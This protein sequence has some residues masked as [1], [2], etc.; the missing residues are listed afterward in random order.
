MKPARSPGSN[1]GGRNTNGASMEPKKQIGIQ[2]TFER[3]EDRLT[4]NFSI[5]EGTP[6]KTF[7]TNQ[8]IQRAIQQS[9]LI[10]GRI[11]GFMKLRFFGKKNVGHWMAYYPFNAGPWLAKI[12][13]AQLLEYRVLEHFQ[14][15]FPAVSRIMHV[16]LSESRLKQLGK[17]G[18]STQYPYSE[19]VQKLRQKIAKD[20]KKTRKR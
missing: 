19:G 14:K 2:I 12:G 9:P 18:T 3:H 5:G 1:P 17:R 15:E 6:S 13:V 4:A 8:G 16:I 7:V 10:P 11:L 20:A